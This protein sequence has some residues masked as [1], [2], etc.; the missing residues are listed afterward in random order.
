[1]DG[2]QSNWQNG[3]IIKTSHYL[4]YRRQKL[5]TIKNKNKKPNQLYMSISQMSQPGEQNK[6]IFASHVGGTSLT[7]FSPLPVET[8][9]L[10]C[11][12]LEGT[13]WVRTCAE[14]EDQRGGRGHVIIEISQ[15]NWRVFHKLLPQVDN[16][17]LS[18]CKN[19]LD[20]KRGYTSQKSWEKLTKLWW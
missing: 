14:D 2:W 7:I 15:V 5:L 11:K 9:S 6:D 16:H 20:G 10:I 8:A 3:I 18:C 17:K 13:H 12:A 4:T 1:M 19:H